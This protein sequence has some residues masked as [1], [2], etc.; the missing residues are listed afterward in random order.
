MIYNTAPRVKWFHKLYEINW[1]LPVLIGLIG[2]VGVVMIF[3]AT[4]GVWNHG[5]QQHL[6]RLI[7]AGM[8]MLVIALIDIK[9]WYSLAYPVYFMCLLLLVSVDIFGI[10]VN[11]AKRW[12]DFG[13][14]RLQPSELMKPAIALA[15]ARFYH[16]LPRWRISHV[17]GLLGATLIIFI[18]TLCVLRQPDLGTS[19]LLFATGGVMVF[20]AGVDWRVITGGIISAAITIPLFLRFGLKDYQRARLLTFFDPERDPTGASYH[21]IQSKIALGSGGFSGKGFMQGTQRQLEY[22]PENSTDFIFTVIGEEFGFVGG[23]AT[24]GLYG[25]LILLCLW[26]SYQCRH[27]FSRL[28]II[29]I[30]ATF[31]FYIFINMA[32]VMGMAPVVGVPL[33]LISYGG[34]V[35]LTV[36]AG[37][38]LILSAHLH[39]A[40]ELPRGGSEKAS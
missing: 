4:E 39:R 24:M 19:I 3:A 40:T 11:G 14:M 32:M 20:I 15:L 33:P 23:V 26:L 22:V 8:M 21:I 1:L 34:T 6:I 27:M 2:L 29:G 36:M 9:V 18:P 12:L 16:D 31:S 37:F 5:A 25:G 7:L 28:L 38:G 35:I 10:H 13:V 17:S 30:T